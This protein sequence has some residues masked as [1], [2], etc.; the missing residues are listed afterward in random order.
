MFHFKLFSIC[1]V[2]KKQFIFCFVAGRIKCTKAPCELSF[3]TPFLL[4]KHQC[5]LFNDGK[6][7]I[8]CFKMMISGYPMQQSLG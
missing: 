5:E 2:G 8:N 1:V 4:T 7:R 3:Q 6:T